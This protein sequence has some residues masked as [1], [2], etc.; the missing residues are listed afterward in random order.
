[1]LK[2]YSPCTKFIHRAFVTS[3][4]KTGKS[5]YSGNYTSLKCLCCTHIAI[6]FSGQ[7]FA[8]SCEMM[9]RC[10]TC[11]FKRKTLKSW[12]CVSLRKK[13]FRRRFRTFEVL[14]AF[15]PRE[16]WGEGKKKST[17]L[18]SSQFSRGQT[19]QNPSEVRKTRQKR[20]LHRLQ[21]RYLFISRS[22]GEPLNG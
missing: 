10:V 16:N 22:T 17:F 8:T 14:F 9:I 5:E 4:T 13:P 2:F 12:S 19:A 11:D 18:P 3:W 20:L 7:G 21:L 15:W 1:M 6:I